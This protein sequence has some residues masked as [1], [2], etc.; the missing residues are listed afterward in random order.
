VHP[1][2]RMMDVEASQIP[3]NVLKSVLSDDSTG[4]VD[5]KEVRIWYPPRGVLR[6]ALLQYQQC[7]S[8][9]EIHEMGCSQYSPHPHKVQEIT[10]H[11]NLGCGL[12]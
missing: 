2:V 5:V 1:D 10:V 4:L 8:R 9:L 7:H 11:E 6:L 12:C 3:K